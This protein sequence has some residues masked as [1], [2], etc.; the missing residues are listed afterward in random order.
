MYGKEGMIMKSRKTILCLVVTAVLVLALIPA[1]SAAKKFPDVKIYRDSYGV[2]HVYS[3]TVY[4]LY[5]GYGYAIATDRLF[6]MEMSKRS[7]EGTVAEVLGV[8]YANFDKGVRSNYRPDSIMAQYKALPK[9]HKEIFDGYA[10]GINARIDEVL[11]DAALMPKQFSDYGF[12]PEKWTAFDVIMIF[13][14]T[15]CNRY[16]DFNAELSNLAFLEYLLGEY[17][18]ETAWDIFDQVKWVNDPG[19]PTTVPSMM[20]MVSTKSTDRSL[21][22]MT[23]NGKGA[24]F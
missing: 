9:N 4:G 10:A 21:R 14:G 5:Y 15:M 16:S 6:Q 8:A 19:A 17:D 18:E 2:P 7:V 12:G 23:G 1:A 13:V 20:S 11:E 3:E 22:R 24:T